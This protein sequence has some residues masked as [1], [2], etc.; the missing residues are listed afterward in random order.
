MYYFHE[1]FN[2]F[3]NLSMNY[4][5]SIINARKLHCKV[6]D[7]CT[8]HFRAV[9]AQAWPK[10]Q[11]ESCSLSCQD[12][13]QDMALVFVSCRHGPKYFMLCHAWDRAKRPYRN[14]PS[15]GVAQV[16]VLV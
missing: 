8:C 15:N 5:C 2:D 12:P 16:P 3:Y 4:L 9:P 11:A 14:P 10:M 1:S 7:M 6:V 13:G